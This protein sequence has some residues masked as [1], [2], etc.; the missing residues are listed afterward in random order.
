MLAFLNNHELFGSIL[1]QCITLGIDDV[2]IAELTFTA[3]SLCCMKVTSVGKAVSLRSLHLVE[4]SFLAEEEPKEA[5]VLASMDPD[6]NQ[7]AEHGEGEDE[8]EYKFEIGLALDARNSFKNHHQH[9]TTRIAII[10][11]TSGFLAG[12]LLVFEGWLN[13][14]EFGRRGE[15][16]L[17]PGCQWRLGGRC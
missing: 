2:S 12:G 5:D 11:G 15:R 16:D 3:S 10:L 4:L 7:Q 1:A 13:R 14:D 6:R 17:W 8:Y 9:H